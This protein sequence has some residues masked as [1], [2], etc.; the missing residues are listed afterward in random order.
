LGSISSTS[1]VGYGIDTSGLVRRA[2][3]QTSAS[4]LPIRANGERAAL[5]VF[6]ANASFELADVGWEAI[7]GA[8][9]LHLGGTYAM[10][11]LDGE[12][13]GQV[14]RFAKEHGAVTTMDVL[15]ARGRRLLERL[16]P[17]LPHL[18]YFMPNLAEASFITGL[19]DP[20]AVGR[21][22]DERGAGAAIIKMDARGSLVVTASG[23]SVRVPAFK[24][25]VVDTTGC[26]DAYCAGF[27]VGLSM[28]WTALA[29]ARLGSAAAGL[30][31]GGLGSDAGI[32]D[33]DQTIAFMERGE[34]I[35]EPDGVVGASS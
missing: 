11:Q 27:I 25:P 8:D 30:V 7:A 2:D 16:E 26:G 23:E 14:L 35:E 32:V 10:R 18:D 6:G 1:C 29:A 15:G 12:P 9:F 21:F 31:A 20:V 5:H 22:I 13:A 34:P 19:S 33:L 17:C 4:M 3:V 28:G 24:V